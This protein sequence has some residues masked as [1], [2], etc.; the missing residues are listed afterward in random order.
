MAF[1]LTSPRLSG[2]NKSIL[3]SSLE[4]VLIGALHYYKIYVKIPTAGIQNQ[5]MVQNE[6][7]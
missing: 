5:N 3:V 2:V 6:P 1:F 7:Q 4:P